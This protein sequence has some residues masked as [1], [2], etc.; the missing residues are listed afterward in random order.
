MEDQRILTIR[1]ANRADVVYFCDKLRCADQLECAA[2]GLNPYDALDMSYRQADICRVALIDGTPMAIYGIGK[3]SNNPRRGN[4]WLLGTDDIEVFKKTFLQHCKEELKT[5]MT[6]YD[7][8]ENL[9]HKDNVVHKR[10]LKWLGFT[11]EGYNHTFDLI[12]YTPENN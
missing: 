4:V 5:L 6:N 11:V 2:H 7:C 3:T 9:M 8:A 10:W 12:S 1:D